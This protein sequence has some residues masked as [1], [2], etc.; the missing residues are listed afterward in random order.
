MLGH[1]NI[2]SSMIYFVAW[3]QS[4]ENTLLRLCG[5]NILYCWQWQI[6]LKNGDTMLS[7]H[8][9]NGYAKES[10]RYV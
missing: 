1:M 7:L 3:Q 10:R 5:N 8:A 9:N 6:Q 4:K 2:K